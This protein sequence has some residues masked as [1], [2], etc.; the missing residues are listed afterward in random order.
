[1]NSFELDIKDNRNPVNPEYYLHLKIDGDDFLKQI[2]EEFNAV[3]F[4]ALQKSTVHSGQY[5]IFTCWCGVADCGGWDYV[6]VTH[7]SEKIT[8]DFYYEQ[9]FHFEFPIDH[10]KAEIARIEF[11]RGNRELTLEPN[12]VIEPE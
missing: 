10:Y 6:K 3:V 2:D 5:L 11:E 9:N 7:E 4:K 8:W 12:N 1:M